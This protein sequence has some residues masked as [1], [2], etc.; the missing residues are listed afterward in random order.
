MI[1]NGVADYI[2]YKTQKRYNGDGTTEQV[3]MPEFILY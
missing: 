3:T 2:D 1:R